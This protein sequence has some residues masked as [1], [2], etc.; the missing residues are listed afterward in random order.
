MTTAVPRSGR[1]WTQSL[2]A[3]AG[4]IPVTSTVSARIQIDLLGSVLSV[5]EGTEGFWAVEPVRV[6]RRTIAAGAA[7]PVSFAAAELPARTRYV[8]LQVTTEAS[9]SGSSR[10][11]RATVSIVRCTR[12]AAGGR[13]RSFRSLS[14]TSRP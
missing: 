2:S 1:S 9:S 12:S 4:R 14:T 5:R 3:T 7:V 11:G 8:L 6:A 13:R 10:C